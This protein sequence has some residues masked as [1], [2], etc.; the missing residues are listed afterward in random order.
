MDQEYELLIVNNTWELMPRP[1]VQNMV[2]C[3]WVYLTEED[4]SE[5]ANI[6]PRYKE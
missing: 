3:K 6:R 1:K 4:V 5:S 2:F